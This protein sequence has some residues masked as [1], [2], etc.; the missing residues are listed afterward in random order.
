MTAV[1][2]RTASV[3]SYAGELGRHLGQKT[4][5][6]ATVTVNSWWAKY[7]EFVGLNEVR[8]AQSKVTEVTICGCDIFFDSCTLYLIKIW[9]LFSF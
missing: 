8:D 3:L 6:A 2:E 4:V 5:K 9:I 1:K 7:E